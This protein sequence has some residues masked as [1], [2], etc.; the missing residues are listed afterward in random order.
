MGLRIRR[1]LNVHLP[2]VAS[3]SVILLILYS[4]C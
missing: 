1:L 4:L 2:S 3:K